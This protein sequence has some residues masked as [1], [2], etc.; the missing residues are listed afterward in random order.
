MWLQINSLQWEAVKLDLETE[1]TNSLKAIASQCETHGGFLENNSSPKN[2]GGIPV[3]FWECR[4][5]MHPAE[6]MDNS[7]PD[8][9][10]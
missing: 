10:S 2:H 3:N 4:L 7:W 5:S 8:F 9:H 6:L 1:K